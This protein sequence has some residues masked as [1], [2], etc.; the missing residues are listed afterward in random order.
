[1]KK[2]RLTLHP[3]PRDIIMAYG[4]TVQDSVFIRCQIK[5]TGCWGYLEGER[6]VHVYVSPKA[7]HRD[8]LEL[9]AHELTHSRF[10]KLT[11]IKSEEEYCRRVA[12][13]C[14]AAYDHTCRIRKSQ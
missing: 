5:S 9:F 4:G 8:I 11:K 6:S 10:H 14:T 7:K 1:M 2:I 13:I 3:T 12:E